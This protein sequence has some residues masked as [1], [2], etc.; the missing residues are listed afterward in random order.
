MMREGKKANLTI[1]V[2]CID[3]FWLACPTQIPLYCCCPKQLCDARGLPSTTLQADLGMRETPSLFTN[4]WW[5]RNVTS[6][7]KGWTR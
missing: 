3:F 4:G 7:S 1:S 6:T 5:R 2:C